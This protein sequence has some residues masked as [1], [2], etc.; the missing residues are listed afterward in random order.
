MI[1][2]HEGHPQIDGVERGAE[3][4]LVGHES[5]GRAQPVVLSDDRSFES[6]SG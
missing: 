2:A 5:A 1:R 4:A 6:L 3:R